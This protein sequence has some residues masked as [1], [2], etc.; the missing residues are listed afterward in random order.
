MKRKIAAS[1]GAGCLLVG[2]GAGY[3]YAETLHSNSQEDLGT[4]STYTYYNTTSYTTT[5][6]TWAM[7]DQGDQVTGGGAN[8]GRSNADTVIQRSDPQHDSGNNHGWH[9]VAQSTDGSS[10]TLTVWALCMHED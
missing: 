6:E 2:I 3:A 9:A 1:L 7:C 10:K 8:T 5:G 4:V